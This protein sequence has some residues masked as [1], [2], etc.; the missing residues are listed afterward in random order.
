MQIICLKNI[1][2]CQSKHTWKGQSS[3]MTDALLTAWVRNVWLE[4]LM[5]IWCAIV[6]EEKTCCLTATTAVAVVVT[7]LIPPSG[8]KNASR[9]PKKNFR[10]CYISLAIICWFLCNSLR[11]ITTSFHQYGSAASPLKPDTTSTNDFNYKH[12]SLAFMTYVADIK[13]G[14]MSLVIFQYFSINNR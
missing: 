14:N 12:K 4:D 2:E 6:V 8:C 9:L 1:L 5:I 10:L 7:L 3:C 11:A 13:C